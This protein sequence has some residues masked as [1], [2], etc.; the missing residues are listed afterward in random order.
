MNKYGYITKEE[1]LNALK[2]YQDTTAKKIEYNVWRKFIKFVKEELEDGL[3]Y[4]FE[5]KGDVLFTIYRQP[6]DSKCIAGDKYLI[7]T[8]VSY[9]KSWEK[10]NYSVADEYCKQSTANNYVGDNISFCGSG[11]LSVDDYAT[12]NM[13]PTYYS[14]TTASIPYYTTTTVGETAGTITPIPLEDKIDMKVKEY[15]EE[16]KE[17][18]NNKM[19]FVKNFNF[20]RLNNPNVRLSPY[21]IAVKNRAGD[22]VSYDVNNDDIIDVEPFNFEDKGFLY[23]MP[24]SIKNIAVGDCIV[25]NKAPCFVVGFAENTGNPIVIDVYEQVKKEILPTK[26]PFG[27]S[28]ATRI[29]NFAEG[30]FAAKPDEDNPF[31][32]MW[33]FALMGDNGKMDD[34]LP[35]MLMMNGGK[36][37]NPM[38]LAMLMSKSDNKD[39]L[40]FLMMGFAQK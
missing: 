6:G 22:W 18:E 7:D 24:V 5:A 39:M 19:D 3:A 4:Y 27:F 33:M 37:D 20:G 28:F 26:S 1:L 12:T 14:T 16:Q 15:F 2:H 34:M 36:M 8:I 17:K 29:T 32:N 21:G 30:M 23:Q 9:G 40:P 25:H 31:G 35:L 13:V 38:L 10:D 11:S